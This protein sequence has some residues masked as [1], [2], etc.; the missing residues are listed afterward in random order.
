[1]TIVPIILKVFDVI[2]HNHSPDPYK[3]VTSNLNAGICKVTSTQY[4][5]L[6][7]SSTL[8]LWPHSNFGDEIK[9]I[10]SHDKLQD[11]L[12]G[13]GYILGP[14]TGDHWFVYVADHSETSSLL[15]RPLLQTLQPVVEAAPS[16]GMPCLYLLLTHACEHHLCHLPVFRVH[17][18]PTDESALLSVLSPLLLSISSSSLFT[19]LYLHPF[20]SF[21]VSSL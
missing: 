5:L 1:M 12:K 18:L 14:I 10:S 2:Q 21:I 13:S 20:T 7:R 3:N 6:F 19:F 16:T 15:N 4:H 11:R 9:Y 17:D 8:Q